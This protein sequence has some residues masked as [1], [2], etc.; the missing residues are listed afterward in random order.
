MTRAWFLR[1]FC[2]ALL[3]LL[4]GVAWSQ[5]VVEGEFLIKFKSHSNQSQTVR[6]KLSGKA[7]MKAAFSKLGLYHVKSYS[8]GFRAELSQDPDIEYVEPN[9]ILRKTQSDIFQAQE[10]S[11]VRAA[12]VST[13]TYDQ[14]FAPIKV[15]EAW[16]QASSIASAGKAI[17]AVIDTGTDTTHPY[18]VSSITNALW[19]NS[20]EIP[21][22]GYDDDMNGFVDDVHGWNFVSNNKNVYDDEGH[23]THVAGIVLGV[24]SDVYAVTLQ[25]SAIQIMTLKFLDAN[26]AGSTANA[27]K[28]IHY[29]IANGAHVINNSWGGGTYSRALHD[30]ITYAY[31]SN[32]VTVAAAGNYG[33]NNDLSP[34]YPASYDVPGNIAVG[35]SDDDDYYA[36][37][38]NF[39]VSTVPLAAPGFEI[40][41]MY[42]QAQISS[43]WAVLSGTS[44]ASPLVAGVAALVRREN[45]QLS[46]Y[47]TKQVILATVDV[48][49][50][51][52]TRVKTSGRVNVLSAIQ[53]AQA[54]IGN[55][56]VAS[57]PSYSPVYQA[58]RSVA[59][60]S[61]ASPAGAGGCGLVKVLGSQG[62]S[63]GG[64]S[65]GLLLV[66]LAPLGLWM[67]LRRQASQTQGREQR[68]HDRFRMQS[69]VT[70]KCGERELV[71]QIN[72]ISQGGLSFDV[73]SALEKGGIVTM[74]IQSPDGQS[75]IE[76]QGHI[77]W[78]EA[79]KSYGVQFDQA[80]QSVLGAI[81]EWTQNL[82]KT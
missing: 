7:Q 76:V 40:L 63:G 47:Q 65:T 2:G 46:A 29:A 12:Q 60:S 50:R 14:N 77:V 3:W 36:Y 70:L 17:V 62:P 32:I 79:N 51:L 33:T 49:T 56:S 66:L 42:P 25:P 68:R 71:G 16:A 35:A 34:L 69:Q 72:T 18:F 38:S 67:H 5:E 52:S 8:P 26:G 80:K 45:P 22:N 44:M 54:T 81:Q 19:V 6:A 4:P 59:S 82:V 48:F 23:G 31:N 20:D 75:E 39:G 21:N 11:E 53:N 24:G 30:A 64:P 43:G 58:E 73:E 1:V 15:Q 13:G 37:F 61:S 55:A 78:S 41:S 28:S 74:K 10:V 27:I 57:Q 9:Y